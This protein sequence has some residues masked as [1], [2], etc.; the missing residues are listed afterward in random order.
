MEYTGGPQEALGESEIFLEF[1][2]SLGRVARVDR[3]VLIIGERGTGK[4]LAAKR[5]HYLS[6][7]WNGPF[8]ALNC[9]SLSPGVIES[10]LFGH[11]RGSFTGATSF[12]KGRFEEANNGTLF[13]DEIGLIP[14]EVQEKILRVVEYGAFQRVG[15]SRTVEVDV[16]I[17]GATNQNL[18]KLCDNGL[19]K[20]DLLDR[21][22]FEVLFLP[23]LRERRND[24]VK[25]ANHFAAKMAR[26]LGR[27]QVP[28]LSDEALRVI[29][30]HHWPGNIRELKNVVER[31]VYR[32]E[33]LV[34]ESLTI[35]PFVYPWQ[36]KDEVAA[37]SDGLARAPNEERAVGT[38]KGERNAD[39]EK[40]RPE[41][42]ETWPINL[43]REVRKLEH[44]CLEEAITRAGGHQSR[45]AELLGLSYNQFRGLY[46][47]V[48]SD[49]NS[50]EPLTT[51]TV[52]GSNP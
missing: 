48:M 37:E 18:P 41:E 36:S 46:R 33:A 45:A 30:E 34:L 42:S 9:A 50:S 25:L 19:F 24:I 29:R 47:R 28:I 8:V 51:D 7:R 40:N 6:P 5:L 3:S 10:E 32:Q 15:S 26:E 4:E 22:S 44:R 38:G 17:L 35:N 31:A 20:L 1:Q 23:P 21:L 43:R 27:K 16:R 52:D 13:L 39:G 2:Q 11:E 49:K 14:I 12:R